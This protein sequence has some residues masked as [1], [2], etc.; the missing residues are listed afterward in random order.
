MHGIIVEVGKGILQIVRVNFGRFPLSHT[1]FILLYSF[2][3]KTSKNPKDQRKR[4]TKRDL[5]KQKTLKDS[6]TFSRRVMPI[7]H[8]APAPHPRGIDL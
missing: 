1:P 7:M 6:E 2:A 5:K 3:P 8:L 4:E